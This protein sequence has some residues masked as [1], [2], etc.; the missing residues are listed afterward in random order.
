MPIQ[1]DNTLNNGY[2]RNFVCT[3]VLLELTNGDISISM[4]EIKVT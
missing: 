4:M 2:I 1:N 3:V